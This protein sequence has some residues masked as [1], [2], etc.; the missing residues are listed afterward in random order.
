MDKCRHDHEYIGHG[1][2][3]Q[4]I[5]KMKEAM[6]LVE[7]MIGAGLNG[8]GPIARGILF[9]SCVRQ[10]GLSDWLKRWTMSSPRNK[11]EAMMIIISSRSVGL[12]MRLKLV[13]KRR[14]SVFDFWLWGGGLKF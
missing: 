13:A 8:L 7:A 11:A 2:P 12:I 5:A 14:M 1:D 6:L 9:V 10:K 3:R 4:F